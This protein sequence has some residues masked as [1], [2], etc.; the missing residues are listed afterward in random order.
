MLGALVRGNPLAGGGGHGVSDA[1][2]VV[3]SLVGGIEILLLHS[4]NIP[5]VKAQNLWIGR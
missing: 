5:R 3:P 1:P 4:T 2:G